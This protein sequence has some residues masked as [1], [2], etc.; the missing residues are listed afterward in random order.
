MQTYF[1]IIYPNELLFSAVGRCSCHLGIVDHKPFLKLLYQNR[2]I[3]AVADLPSH[4]NTL[5]NNTAQ[6]WKLPPKEIIQQHTL[7]PIYDHFIGP[8]RKKSILRLMLGNSGIGIHTKTGMA[9]SLV[10]PVRFFRYC[11]LCLQ[12]MKEKYGEL[13]WKRDH[14][15]N[16]LDVCVKHNL[17]LQDSKELFRPFIRHNHFSCH[18]DNINQP[19]V[20]RNKKQYNL[21]KFIDSILNTTTSSAPT[22]WQWS[23]YYKYLSESANLIKGSRTDHRLIQ[24]NFISFW[25][26]DLLTAYNLLPNSDAESWLVNIFRKHKKAFS[27]LQHALVIT[28]FSDSNCFA[29]VLEKVYQFPHQ[30]IKDRK[31]RESANTKTRVKRKAWINLI[32]KYPLYGVTQ[33]RNLDKAKGL[34]SWLYRHDTEWLIR[35][36][37]PISKAKDGVHFSDWQTRDKQLVAQ[38]IKINDQCS[39]QLDTPRKSKNWFL[40]QL[41]NSASL[42]KNMHRLPLCNLFFLRYVETVSEYQIRRIT[43]ILTKNLNIKFLSRWEIERLAGLNRHKLPEMTKTFLQLLEQG[44]NEQDSF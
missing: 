36:N 19:E 38:L 41:K 14:Q 12:D 8:Y 30:Q 10:A 17:T 24:R 15:I 40:K 9:A 6:F 4:I 28:A 7:F 21:A 16:G 1:P 33:L 27:Y 13:Y 2:N 26:V 32:A 22:Q 37:K 3:V 43:S 20:N 31:S 34:Y 29:N 23:C 25:G 42:G 5:Y 39:E 11:P 44:R 35:T 18:L